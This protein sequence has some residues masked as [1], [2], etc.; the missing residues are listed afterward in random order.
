MK[1][2]ES[3]Y[4]VCPFYRGEE[5]V[6]IFCEGPADGASAKIIF[7]SHEGKIEYRHTYCEAMSCCC[8]YG[9]SLAATYK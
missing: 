6:A 7:G 9:R 8:A 4:V 5:S 1:R 2:Y 3:K